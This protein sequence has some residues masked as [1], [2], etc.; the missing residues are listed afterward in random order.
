M[1]AAIVPFV[2]GWEEIE[3][4]KNTCEKEKPAAFLCKP[5]R[6]SVFYSKRHSP[7]PTG[8][9][10]NLPP[11]LSLAWTRCANGFRSRA[12]PRLFFNEKRLSRK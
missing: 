3:L 10:N 2:D 6:H 7:L 9:H 11:N 4:G 12:I 8:S 1:T 5:S